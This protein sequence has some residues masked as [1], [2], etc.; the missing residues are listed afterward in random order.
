VYLFWCV[1]EKVQ[2]QELS[3]LLVWTSFTSCVRF[4]KVVTLSGPRG[5]KYTCPATNQVGLGSQRIGKSFAGF[6]ISGTVLGRY[7]FSEL[8]VFLM[9]RFQAKSPF[10][11]RSE[12][13]KTLLKS[14]GVSSH[15]QN[16]SRPNRKG[17]QRKKQVAPEEGCRASNCPSGAGSP[18]GGWRPGWGP[19]PARVGAACA[20]AGWAAAGGGV[21]KLFVF[22]SSKL[23]RG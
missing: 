19:R 1:L 8:S 3:E 18:G 5:F 23:L 15:W 4:G 11:M 14:S 9:G 12:R 16:S 10:R 7:H 2:D 21:R 13:K 17:S 20:G 6:P 22:C